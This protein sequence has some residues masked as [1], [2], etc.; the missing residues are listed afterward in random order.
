MGVYHHGPGDR[1]TYIYKF[2]LFLYMYKKFMNFLWFWCKCKCWWFLCVGFK[3]LWVHWSEDLTKTPWRLFLC[4]YIRGLRE[5]NVTR[6]NH[7]KRIE[8]GRM[9]TKICAI[10]DT[11]KRH[12]QT[13]ESANFPVRKS[14]ITRSE[15]TSMV[16]MEIDPD[17]LPFN[18]CSDSQRT[19]S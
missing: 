3:G 9:N 2:R 1:Y 11:F 18:S 12:K 4:L 15:V 13:K 7:L 19:H 5:K 17:R 16:A 8:D 10:W 14:V 6:K